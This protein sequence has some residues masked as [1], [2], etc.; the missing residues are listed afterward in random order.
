MT[1][2]EVFRFE[3][4][5]RVR[6]PSTWVYA[7]VLLAVPF[8]LLHA[9]NGS[10]QYLNA[11]VAVMQGCVVLGGLGMLITAGI[12]GDAAS[13]DVQ[14]RM[15]SLFYTS[16]VS[17]SHY[18]AG[19]FLGGALVNAVLVVA[20][21]LGLLI[22]SLMPYMSAGKFGP[23]QLE[24]YVQA[25]VLVLLPNVLIIG[26]FMFATAVLTRQALA[27]YLGGLVLFML[28][29]IAADLT[30]GAGGPVVQSLLSPF[31]NSAISEITRLWTPVEQN[32]R[33]IGWPALVFMNRALWI[34][35]AAAVY[36]VL[37]ARFRFA[38]S[39][40]TARRRW[41]RRRTVVDTAPDKL[42]PLQTVRHAEARRS[43]DF[44]ARARQAI[45]VAA[46]S[47]REIA[48]TK[49]F[50]LILAGAMLFVLTAGWDVGTERFGTS[51]W[52]VTHLVAGTVLGS[53]LPPV[54]ALLIAIF[55]GELVWRE[56]EIGMGD[57][58]A[59]AP[60]SNG[61]A[62]TGR[63]VALLGMLVLLQTAFMVA[64]IILQA[65]QGYTHFE[66]GVYLELLF[67][68]KLVDYFLLA[69][70]AMAVQVIVNNKYL[71]HLIVVLYFASTMAAG[72]LGITNRMFVYGSDPGWVWSDMNG[73]AP[74]V[75]GLVWFK[76]YWAAWAFL[77]AILA[78]LFWVRGRELGVRRRLSLARQRLHGGMLRAA[79]LAMALIVTLG[80][81][82]FYNTHIVN[83]YR[84]P[85]EIA[86]QRAAYERKY[87]RY[88]NAP[89]PNLFAVHLSVEMYPAQYAAQIKGT[90]RYV[91]RTDRAI[92]TLHV[93]SSQKVA[94]SAVS[95]DRPAKLAV[96][97]AALHYSMYVLERSI[98]P[99]DSIAMTIQLDQRPRGFQNA[100]AP[101]DVTPNAVYIEGDW[102]PTLGYSVGRE[103]SD[104]Q[105]RRELGL[106]PRVL[107]PSGGDVETRL[108]TKPIQLVDVETIIGTDTNQTAV[109]PG[110]LIREWTSNGRRYFQY[111]TDEPLRYGGAILS[112][113][114]AIRRDT[115]QGVNLAV[116]YHPAHVVN[117][118][119]MIR[120]M[121]A[122]LA[123][124]TTNFG[125]YQF[126]ELRIVE[127]PRY[128][129]FAR[130]HPYTI[131]FSEGGAFLTRVDSGD[132]DR[133]FFVVAHETAHQWWGG[134]VIP[135]SAPG[136][137]FVSETMAQYSSMMVL[138]AA[139]GETIARRFYDY[140]MDEYFT[141]RSMYTNR[142]A[143]LLDVFG[144]AYVY[145]MKGA[146]A[147]YTLRERL[148]A[149]A[150]NGALRRFR[151]KY[152]GTSAPPATSRA[153][154]TE[155]ESVTPDSLKTL[156]SDLFEHI[157]IWD[158]KTDSVKAEPVGGG[159]YRVKLFVDAS[160]ARADSVG[161]KS[162]IA[163][164]DLVEVGVF[165]ETTAQG[166]K[167]NALYL[168]QQRIRSG[169]Q[170]VDITVPGKPVR[171]GVDPS[172][173]MF[174]RERGDNVV[175]V[176]VKTP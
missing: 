77:F 123:Y 32:S 35:I 1:L 125:P 19:R 39:G 23:V 119:R 11:P 139:Y 172:R 66:I 38:H 132:V 25:Y 29:T 117:V 31:G 44:G 75:R 47:W 108:G 135:A 115:A 153:L 59:V 163:M 24:A 173:K 110:R 42:V 168:K 43:F 3:V 160:K 106:R 155:L 92:D 21:P 169:K 62:L 104:E 96:D 145:Y 175:G 93:L 141:N 156:L 150:V 109:T 72:L 165:G 79:A 80:G 2:G 61:V 74:F 95:F 30:N 52:P 112:G 27:T 122:S 71:G 148:G 137:A 26:A 157:T 17:E 131:T 134:Q 167:G 65:L 147:M 87:K 159:A 82:V 48:A 16:P 15:H 51:I 73:L 97:D 121:R 158:L 64:G 162:P 126:K 91:N 54:I 103:L 28:G 176:S 49:V 116:Y 90:L 40:G 68:I 164:D 86:E 138:E 67:G 45:A 55:A 4:G 142:E 69:A 20:I 170:I 174:E 136:S 128:A 18:L 13:R 10:R 63:F 149:D 36:V 78:G 46:R 22:G 98:A 89:S 120:S 5:Y 140:N 100:G 81:F 143:P 129:E 33:L 114:Y 152:A 70:L 118:D 124:Y 7:L 56:R 85:D 154:Y 146:V 166:S 105:K 83:P 50:L 58:A 37:V 144:Q 76:L 161:N 102:L 12:F 99:G 53:L 8:L 127:F 171:A 57:I 9:I 84:T 151:E 133:T 113:A 130:A 60:I 107:P 111:K 41:W 101:T 88:E 6:Q 14:T 94:R 34:G